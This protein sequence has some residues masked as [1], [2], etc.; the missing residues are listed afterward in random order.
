MNV[1]V[2]GGELPAQRFGNCSGNAAVKG[3]YVSSPRSVFLFFIFYFS[4]PKNDC[5]RLPFFEG[6]PHHLEA[7][8]I[9]GRLSLDIYLANSLI[10]SI[11]FF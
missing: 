6:K 8:K 5:M 11:N 2:P 1:V 3:S 9:G 10:R 4:V 7:Y